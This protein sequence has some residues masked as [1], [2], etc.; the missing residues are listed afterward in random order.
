[1]R[2]ALLPADAYP[3]F[4]EHDLRFADLDPMGHA[5]NA[6]FGSAMESSR[7]QMLLPYARADAPV[8]VVLARFEIDYLHELHWPGRL[9]AG[10]AVESLGHKSM[11]LRQAIFTGDVC[12][13]QA[14]AIVVTLDRAT[15]RAVPLPDA[16]REWLVPY[17][18]VD[19]SG[20]RIT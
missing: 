4:T 19:P 18:L 5:N 7:T 15:R 20:L 16:L 9:R 17:A 10:T 3:W 2:A 6:V 14:V 1:M 11:R 12:A 13:A 8:T